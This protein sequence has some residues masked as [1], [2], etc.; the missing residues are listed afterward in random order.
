MSTMDGKEI[1]NQRNALGLSRSQAAELWGINPRTLE[2]LEQGRA[3]NATTLGLLATII[4]Y[5]R[6]FGPP[7]RRLTH[8]E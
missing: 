8:D 5:H 3:A 7:P 6:D 1:L 2:S 4:A